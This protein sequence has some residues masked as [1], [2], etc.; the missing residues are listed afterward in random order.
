[1]HLEVFKISP[2][3]EVVKDSRKIDSKVKNKENIKTEKIE[4]CYFCHKKFDIN[5][6]D[7][8][9]YK[10]GK[11]PMCSYCAEFYGFYSN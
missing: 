7:L 5:Q 10:Y 2:D 11:Y 6:E 4:I 1:M 9:Y 8:S 3:K